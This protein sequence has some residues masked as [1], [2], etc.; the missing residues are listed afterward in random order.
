MPAFT[1]SKSVLIDAPKAR[2]FAYVRDFK[3]WP[4]WS[5]WLRSEPACEVVQH[6][7]DAYSW[8]GNI[9]GAGKMAVTGESGT[10]RIDYQLNFF[11]PWKSQAG[12][13]FEFRETDGGTEVEWRMESKLPLFMFWMKDTLVGM[14]G[15]DYQRGLH[16]LKHQLEQ[17]HIPSKLAFLGTQP[18]A[19]FDYMGVRDTCAFEEIG[20]SMGGSVGQLT[21]WMG[22]HGVQA[23]G[24]RFS[25]YHKWDLKR[26][27]AEYTVGFP[28]DSV[29]GS[30]PR[31]MV[32]GHLPAG[33]TYVVQ[34]TGA[35]SFLGNAWSG[36]MSHAQAKVFKQN[37]KRAPFEVDVHDAGDPCSPENVTMVHLPAS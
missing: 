22:K 31:T 18:F 32:G 16:M 15:N 8:D 36:G 3:A 12:V 4:V 14:I 17:G 27:L 28:V 21:D 34:H 33:P 19:G 37:K 25:I 24:E 26:G 9:V 13:A 30:L 20:E 6:G 29:P 23:A 11:K 1:V 10:D 7:D 5:P 35:Y 2:V